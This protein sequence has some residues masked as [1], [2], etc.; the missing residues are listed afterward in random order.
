[1]CPEPACSEANWLR[2][3]LEV[4]LKAETSDI[5]SDKHTADF[6]RPMRTLGD[7]AHRYLAD[8][9]TN[10][11]PEICIALRGQA[12]MEIDGRRM[13]FGGGRVAFVKPGMSHSERCLNPR[14]RYALL[15]LVCSGPS[16]L[17]LVSQYEPASGWD[18]PLTYSLESRSAKKLYEKMSTP[19]FRID[20]ATFELL[21]ADLIVILGELIAQETYQASPDSDRPAHVGRHR[22]ILQHVKAFVDTHF[23]TQLSVDELAKLS[24]VT[25]NYLNHLFS[26]YVGESLH[27]YLIRKRMEEALRL[28]K[29]TDLLVKQ[30]AFRVGYRDSHY[31][32]R[33]FHRFHG[34]RPSD[35]RAT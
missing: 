26:Q 28:C 13:R 5:V 17:G 16:L 22:Q 15:W 6:V 4:V 8:P 24:R 35:Y 3:A 14:Y 10:V 2:L 34:C 33:A 29:E 11:C 30:I 25:P 18:R 31:F 9:H 7:P 19:T 1:M 23:N 32:S 20:P 21:R 12:A 27:A